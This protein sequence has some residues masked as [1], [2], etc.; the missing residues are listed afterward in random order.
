MGAID[1]V[2]K[3]FQDLV[4]P[5][6]KSLQVEIK[7]VEEASKLRDEALSAKIDNLSDKL[8]AKIDNLS[9]QMSSKIDNLSNQMSSKIDNLSDKVDR[10]FE[11]VLAKMEAN[12]GAIVY[13]LNIDK[14]V[15]AIERKTSASMQAT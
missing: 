7:S 5:E 14:R 12:Q 11:I 6:L 8:T 10:K 2:R 15:E 3:V 13:A 4:A 9:N 1:D